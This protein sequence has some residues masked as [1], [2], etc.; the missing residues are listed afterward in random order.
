MTT[1]F[2]F[3]E[4]TNSNDHPELVDG[5][6]AEALSTPL[7]LKRLKYLACAGEEVRALVGRLLTTS[8]YRNTAL[9]NAVGGSKT[10]SHLLGN[11]GDFRPLDMPIEEAWEIIKANKDRLTGIRK[12][13]FE[14][15]GNRKWLHIEAKIK[16]EEEL[17][18]YTT[19]NGKNYTKV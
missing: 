2:T 1:N 5:N 18:L 3:K 7:I 13:I 15:V 12:I 10:S 19:T 8:G 4:L 6:R 11:T 16:A 9:N 14:H 17:V